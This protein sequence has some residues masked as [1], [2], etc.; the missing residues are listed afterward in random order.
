MSRMTWHSQRHDCGLWK[1]HPYMWKVDQSSPLYH[2]ILWHGSHSHQMLCWLQFYLQHEWLNEIIK[3]PLEVKKSIDVAYRIWSINNCSSIFL[4]KFLKAYSTIFVH[5]RTN[6]Y[7]A[8]LPLHTVSI[9]ICYIAVHKCKQLLVWHKSSSK[10]KIHLLN[11]ILEL[12][13]KIQESVF[14]VLVPNNATSL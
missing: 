5:N 14:G 11:F 7:S 13:E 10:Y 6:S 4:N 9:S 8:M 1:L 2:R 12:S 3:L